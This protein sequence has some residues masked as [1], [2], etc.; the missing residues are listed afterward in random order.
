MDRWH[1]MSLRLRHLSREITAFDLEAFFQFSAAE[2]RV[3]E[4]P[5]GHRRAELKLELA[6]QSGLLHMSVGR[7]PDEVTWMTFLSGSFTRGIRTSSS[8][9]R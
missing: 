9:A 4:G 1:A 3:I 5:E 7:L 6:L 8:H 2:C